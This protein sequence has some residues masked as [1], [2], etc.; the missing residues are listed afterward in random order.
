MIFRVAI[1]LIGMIINPDQVSDKNVGAG[2]L[3]TRVVTSILLLLLFQPTGFLLDRNPEDLG[4]LHRLQSA[5]IGTENEAGVIDRLFSGNVNVSYSGTKGNEDLFSDIYENNLF[6]E[7]VYAAPT[8]SK[9]CY[10]YHPVTESDIQTT[11]FYRIT[12]YNYAGNNTDRD[13]V[14]EEAQLWMEINSGS[15]TYKGTTYT[16][17]DYDMTY[18]D[19]NNNSTINWSDLCNNLAFDTT[20]NEARIYRAT[21]DTPASGVVYG[22]NDMSSMTTAFA[23]DIESNR[24]VYN[25]IASNCSEDDTHPACNAIIETGQFNEW[26]PGISQSAQQFAQSSLEAFQDCTTESEE[27]EN[28]KS[29]QFGLDGETDAVEGGETIVDLMV[30]DELSLDTILA[31]IAGIALIVFILLLC[32]DVVVRNLKL[33]LLEMLAPIPIISYVD[34]KDKIFNNWLK[35]YVSVYVDLFLKLIAINLC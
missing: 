28:A 5:I 20:I 17:V 13:R 30:D 11:P 15:E 18:Y 3:L 23:N 2:K 8:R 35:S 12:F 1:G 29:N 33:M 6:F 10:F 32:V 34:P 24:S 19:E 31:L 21:S 9:T 22:F 26:L 27:C 14:S 7:N 25:T 16:F 4:L